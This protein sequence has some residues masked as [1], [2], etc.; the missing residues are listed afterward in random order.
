M[1]VRT[2]PAAVV[3]HGGGCLEEHFGPFAVV[4]RYT[5]QNE[6]DSVLEALPPA[7]AGTVQAASD[8]DPALADLVKALTQRTGRVIVNGYPTGVAV[9]W[10][11]HHGGPYPA[12]T[13]P[14]ETSVGAASV[15]RWLRPITLQNTP[16]NALPTELRDEALATLPH[17][18]N[19]VQRLG[20]QRTSTPLRGDDS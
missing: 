12:S 10:A 1:V 15:R 20:T 14:G 16:A 17:R 13:A 2:N 3:E 8:F 4:V 7:L 6:R 18:L 11:M 9:S 5:S 19:G